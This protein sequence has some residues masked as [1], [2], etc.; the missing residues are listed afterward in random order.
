MLWMY[1][2]VIFGPVTHT[3]NEA[4]TDLTLPRA[5]GVRA[6]PASLIFWMGVYPQPFL[7]RMQPALDPHG[8]ARARRAIAMTPDRRSGSA[9]RCG[10]AR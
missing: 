4:L 3:E 9:G 7:D 5:A 8:R 6:A 1:Q 10:G 2:R